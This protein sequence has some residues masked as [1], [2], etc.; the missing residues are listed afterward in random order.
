V[1]FYIELIPRLALASK[2]SY[3]MSTPELVELKLQIKEM[4]DK[5]YTSPS[6]LPWCAP[7][8]FVMKKSVLSNYALITSS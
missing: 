5:G 6:V 3:K 1:D 8:L 7:V 4:L 2:A